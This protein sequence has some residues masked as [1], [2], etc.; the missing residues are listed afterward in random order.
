MLLF[1]ETIVFFFSSM[2]VFNTNGAVIIYTFGFS[3]N[4]NSLL[5]VN[6]YTKSDKYRRRTALPEE[7]LYARDSEKRPPVS[8]IPSL[9]PEHM[10]PPTRALTRVP[11]A[12]TSLK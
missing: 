12:P 2:F 7:L 9:S 4:G 1:V 8:M 5:T 11:S 3:L 6:Q 10:P